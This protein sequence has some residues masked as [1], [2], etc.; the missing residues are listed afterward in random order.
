M[1]ALG[2]YEVWFVTGSQH[3]YGAETL[4]KVDQNST[5]IAQALDSSTTIPVKVVFKPLLTT[6]EA[7]TQ[8][9]AEANNSTNCIGLVAWMHTFSPAKMW[10]QGLK[11][12]YKPLLDF[13]TQ[14]GRDIPWANIDMDFMNLNQTAHGG[15][16]FGFINARMRM[17]RKVV[18]GHWAVETV[19]KQIG[20][21]TRA[22]AAWHDAQG[23]KIARFG[24]NM[25]NVAVTEGDKVGAQM[26][27]GFSVHG[28]GM[29]DLVAY[30]SKITDQEAEQQVKVYAQEYN[31]SAGTLENAAKKNTLMSEAKIEL[32]LRRFLEDGN[33]KGFTTTFEDL[34]G[35]AQ[36]PGLAVQ[37]LMADGYGFG[38]EGDWKT[39]ALL[40]MTKVM[41]KGLE[42]GSSFMEDY[43]YHL[44][45][46]N[47][48]VLGS[49]MLEICPSIARNKPTLE[50]H[51]LF[52]G[53]KADPARL[54]FDVAEG[55][56]VNAA[57]MDMGNRY[58]LL[59]NKVDVVAC[60]P[61]PK[62]PVA[63]VMWEPKPSLEIATSAWI[64]AGGA[65]HTAF[66]KALTE[67]HFEDLALIAG[68]EFVLIDEQ[69]N[70]HQFRNELRWNDL[71]FH[72]SK[73]IF[74]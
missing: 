22:A 16:E 25:H 45:P 2:N 31:M 73:G 5:Q 67:E 17:E 74:A 37:R 33:F 7:I 9:C 44:D 52:I 51:P 55:K 28:Y 38:A 12:L 71:Y 6:P 11:I 39:A 56:A 21:W 43:T 53:G 68:I 20:T 4:K 60:E 70:I 24:D 62:L 58:R 46:A 64:M 35:L 34:H 8:I 63:R 48:K 36:L 10:I 41:D 59:L 32:G 69:T 3:L 49:H 29:G 54:V 30:V 19:Q 66:S 65:H 26:H 14:F 13:H 61:M 18:V 1:K 40:R 27:L 57:L 42:G 50:I 15:R 72:I 23:G 47:P